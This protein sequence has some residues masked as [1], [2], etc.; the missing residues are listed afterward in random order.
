MARQAGTPVPQKT[1]PIVTSGAA[2]GAGKIKVEGTGQP[3]EQIKIDVLQDGVVKATYT[4]NL[5]NLG[6]GSYTFEN[7]PAGTYKVEVTAPHPGGTLY[8]Y[9]GEEVT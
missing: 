5:N 2:V 4:G 9:F 1:P 7:L 8:E 3:N 6:Q